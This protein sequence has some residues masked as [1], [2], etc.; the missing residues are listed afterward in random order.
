MEIV[1]H[2]SFLTL[3]CNMHET[4]IVIYECWRGDNAIHFYSGGVGLL[5]RLGHRQTR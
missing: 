3:L 1:T 5:S 2:N 4:S